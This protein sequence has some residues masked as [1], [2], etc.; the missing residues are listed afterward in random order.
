MRTREEWINGLSRMRRNVYFDGQLI[1]RD[2]ELQED[3]FNVMGTTFDEALKPENE[4]LMT[5]VSH[6][7]GNKINR[8]T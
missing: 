6:L 3:C 8:F 4:G 1:D 7:T 2:C 5:A